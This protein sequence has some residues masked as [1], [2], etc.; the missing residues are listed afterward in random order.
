MSEG[1][2]V[3]DVIENRKKPDADARIAAVTATSLAASK[4]ILCELRGRHGN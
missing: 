1:E 4:K 3:K 2:V